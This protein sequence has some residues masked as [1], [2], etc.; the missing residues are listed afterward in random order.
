VS[1]EALTPEEYE[2]A[3]RIIVSFLNAGILPPRPRSV[4]FIFLHNPR[5]G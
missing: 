4:A 5:E 2:A 3:V 1:D